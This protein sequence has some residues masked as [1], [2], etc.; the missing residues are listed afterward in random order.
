MAIVGAG[1]MGTATAWPLSDN[2][3][4]VRLVG[5]HLDGDIIK[6][7][8]ER[9]FHP[10][11]KRELPPNVQPYYVE[12]IAEA[13]DGVEIIVS[14]VNSLGVHWIGRTIGPYLQPGQLIIAV[15][16]GLEAAPNGDLKI[17]PDVLAS[18]LP[19][20]IRDQVKLAAIGGPCIA[21]EL[22]GRRQTCVVFG[23]RDGEAVERLAA[24]FRTSYYHVWTTTDL[25]GLEVCAALKN[26][27]TLGVGLA[28]GLLERA[29]GPDSADAHMHNLAAAIF[30]QG[31]TEIARM[32]QIVGG[33]SAFAYGLPGP[34]DLYVT[35]MGGR[36]VRL[37]RLLGQ[38]HTYTEAR[39]IMAG[40]TLES[41][42]I[43]RTMGEALPKLIKRG[44]VASDEVPLLRALI[45]IVV[46]GRPVE[47]PL[48]AFFSDRRRIMS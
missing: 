15:T 29:G 36:T 13:L 2:G 43:I 16:K 23:S 28:A 47:L 19:E 3:H 35:S 33:S 45:D 11:L 18:E 42:E 9:R 22:A 1:L 8:K 37:G 5:T 6:S 24:A 41:A 17:L 14:G 39:S 25:V 26:A 46:Y 30:A 40:E 34:G 20:A 7:C 21:G 31:C 27:Y 38:G 4:Q 48:D 12:E 44:L 10:R 32:L